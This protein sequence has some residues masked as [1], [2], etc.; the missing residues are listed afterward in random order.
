MT[1]STMLGGFPLRQLAAKALLC[2]LPLLPMSQAAAT[3]YVFTTSG[4]SPDSGAAAMDVNDA[5]TVVGYQYDNNSS[6]TRAFVYA[7]GV[8]TN[9]AGPSGAISV[10]LS[11]ITNSGLM[12]G[13]YSTTWVDDGTGYLYP[14][15]SRIFS[16]LNGAYAD[17]D[18]PGL[19]AATVLGI[20]SNGRWIV[21]NQFDDLGHGRGFAFDI[22]PGGVVTVFDGSAN[23]IVAAGVNNLGVV[24]G[25]DR[26]QVVGVGTL[27]PAWTFDL[28]TGQRTEFN[29]AGSQRTGARNI[30]DVGVI[31]GYYYTSLRPAVAHG[32]TGL[33][34]NFEF[35]DVPGSSRTSVLAGNDVGMLVGVYSDASGNEGAFLAVPVPEPA[36]AWL[37]LGGLAGL[38]ALRRIQALPAISA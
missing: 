3:N 36:A 37:L 27:G 2:L 8:K 32:F 12:V 33:G 13:N 20:S 34:G 22:L 10:D 26:S 14:G 25:F 38:V 11:G 18:V 31:S 17:I 4:T 16:Q 19:P 30:T 24:V 29:V 15:P 9:L 35:F 1:R 23:N 21:G 7:G 6:A 5:G 28:N